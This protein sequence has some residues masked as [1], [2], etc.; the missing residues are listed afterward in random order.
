MGFLLFFLKATSFLNPVKYQLSIFLYFY[1]YGLGFGGTKNL[2]Y[3]GSLPIQI[4]GS[5]LRASY[6]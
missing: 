2:S 6:F 4:G 5:L 3:R 1:P